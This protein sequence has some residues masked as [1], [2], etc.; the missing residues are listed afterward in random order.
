[1]TKNVGK[2]QADAYMFVDTCDQSRRC[3]R[4]TRRDAA[5]AGRPRAAARRRT[6]PVARDQHDGGRRVAPRCICGRG[7]RRPVADGYRRERPR[8]RRLAPVGLV[9]SGAAG[10]SS[11]GDTVSVACGNVSDC[12]G[13]ASGFAYSVVAAAG[14]RDFS[15]PR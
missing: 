1:M 8:E 14:S 12:S 6:V 3:D 9:L 7:G 2:T 15:V 4:R 11:V 5:A 13:D 10:V